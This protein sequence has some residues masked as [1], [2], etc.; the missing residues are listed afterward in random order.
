MKFYQGTKADW[1]YDVQTNNYELVGYGLDIHNPGDWHASSSHAYVDV[2]MVDVDAKRNQ[3]EVPTPAS[4]PSRDEPSSA[5][6]T[7]RSR[8]C[9]G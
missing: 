1:S 3:S 2:D 6:N 4:E 5:Q 7:C 9:S 8:C